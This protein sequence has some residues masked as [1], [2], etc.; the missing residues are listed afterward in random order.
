[1]N[2][3]P[4]GHRSDPLGRGRSRINF[5]EPVLESSD[6]NYRGVGASL[7]QEREAFG[8][9]LPA[10]AAHLRIQQRYLE[11]IE[12]GRF[13]A[14]PGPTYAAGFLRSYGG[15]LGLDEDALLRAYR[16]ET[17]GQAMQ[18]RLVFPTPIEEARRPGIAVVLAAGGGTRFHGAT[19]KLLAPLRGRPPP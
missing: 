5:R 8:L 18:Q 7:R 13:A 16:E 14:L 9:A 3:V 17:S 12:D 2:S 11:A 4:S 1:M 15:Y 6:R 10:V 19:H